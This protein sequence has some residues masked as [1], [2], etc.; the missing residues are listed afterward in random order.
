M[1]DM[2]HYS[3]ET[4]IV[5]EKIL[6]EYVLVRL[7]TGDRKHSRTVQIIATGAKIWKLLKEGKDSSLI[8]ET[9]SESYEGIEIDI[10]KKD[11][12]SFLDSLYASGYL[13]KTMNSNK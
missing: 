8:A 4:D 12:A 6:E 9:L 2:I 7:L 11:I 10:L 3:P 1:A 5:L 13:K